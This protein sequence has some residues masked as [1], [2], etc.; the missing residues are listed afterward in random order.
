VTLRIYDTLSRAKVDFEPLDPN[1]IRFYVCG[2]TVYDF[3]HIGNARPVVVFDVLSRLLRRLYPQVTY[4]RNITDVEDKIN[5]RA[6]QLGE[7]IR[8]LTERTA[9]Q[10]HDDMAAL[11]TQPPDV[12]P[13]ATDHIVEMI[14]MIEELIAKGHA[15]AADG[16][17]M[18]DVPSMADYGK[19]SRHS[20]DELVAGARV[21]VAP[22]KKDAADFVLWKPSDEDTP[23]WDSPW[24]RGRP[25]W[26]IECSAMSMKYLGASF[27]IHGGGQDLIFPH[28]ENEIAQSRCSHPEAIFAKYWMHN[29]YL[30]AEGEKMSKS[31]GN[32]YTVHELLDE[33]PGEA[34]RL[35]LLQTHYRQ[36]LDFTKEGLAQAKGT[37]DRFYLALR[38]NAAIEVVATEAPDLQ[39]ALE[40]DLNTPLALSHLHGAVTDLNKAKTDAEKVAAKGRLLAGAELLGL[41]WHDPEAWLRGGSGGAA[42]GG[43]DDS[44]IDRLVAERIEARKNKDFATADRIRDELTAAGILLEDG[45]QG[46]A[47]RRG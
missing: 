18:F 41:L 13:R 26:H 6:K 45:P 34:I 2:P 44:E 19:L 12:E 25:G 23:G 17:V 10:F 20:R 31:L 3:A 27:D 15:Y 22:Y 43:L 37:L 16:H 35:A 24:G 33:F 1:H 21:E 32:F 46:T 38:D 5:D 47:W 29:G 8:T 14:A 30:M 11:G 9:K 40:D 36:P 39:A 42:A 4:V 28:H 7:D